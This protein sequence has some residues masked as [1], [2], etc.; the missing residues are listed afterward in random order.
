MEN[1]KTTA[2]KVSKDYF[3]NV[4]K[5]GEDNPCVRCGRPIENDKYMVHLVLGGELLAVADEEKYQK[6]NDDECGDMGF[7]PVGSECK[8]HI[9]KEYIHIWD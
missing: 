5:F 3:R 7:H 1:Y 2:L 4:E 6:I 9:G 8:N